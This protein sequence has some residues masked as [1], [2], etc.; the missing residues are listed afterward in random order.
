M[1]VLAP[2]LVT[3]A[4]GSQWRA[5]GCPVSG[6][7]AGNDVPHQLPDERFALEGDRQGVSPRL[8]AGAVCGIRISGCVVGHGWGVTGVALG[9]LCAF[10]I[11]YLMM[12]HLSLSLVQSS[13]K[14]FAQVQLPAFRLTMLVGGVTLAITALT[15]HLGFHPLAGLLTGSFAALGSAALAVWLAPKLVL[16][17][18]GVRMY[19]ILRSQ[20][21]A[22]VAP[23]AAGAKIGMNRDGRTPSSCRRS[24]GGAQRVIVNL[25][26][27]I[28][29]RGLPV[30]VVLGIG[31]G[32]FLTSYLQR[33]GWWIFALAGPAEYWSTQRVSP[34]RAAKGSGLLDEPWQPGRALG[35]QA[36]GSGTPSW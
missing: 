29:D 14:Q 4:F 33:C 5:H 9:V 23:R 30:D 25:A 6:T 21:L 34:A 27:G 2:E 8:A 10:F 36:R 31:T 19:D 12:A 20:L 26:D 35:R 15:R 16:G 17:E 32:V 13:W 18:H 28:I 24:G 3:M 22:P 1:A 11:N 7:G